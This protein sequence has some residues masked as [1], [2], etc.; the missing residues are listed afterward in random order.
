MDWRDSSAS[1]VP[2]GLVGLSPF[3]HQVTLGLE[4]MEDMPI[5]IYI[6][7]IY[8]LAVFHRRFSPRKT[9]QKVD[10]H[11]LVLVLFVFAI[12]IDRMS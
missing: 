9:C 7:Y 1:Q 10:L 6:L 2:Y 8:S 4:D 3:G 11:I 5:K 12:K